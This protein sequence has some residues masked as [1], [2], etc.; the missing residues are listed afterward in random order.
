MSTLDARLG[1]TDNYRISLGRLV[2]ELRGLAELHR[3]RLEQSQRLDQIAASWPSGW[4]RQDRSLLVW[5]LAMIY[6]HSL[7]DCAEPAT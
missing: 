4:S 5:G 7:L 6:R 1:E 3:L 2:E